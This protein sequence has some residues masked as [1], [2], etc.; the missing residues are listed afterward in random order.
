MCSPEASSTNSSQNGNDHVVPHQER[1]SREGDESLAYGVRNGA[2]EQKHCRDNRAH[3]LWC[4]GEGILETS[5]GGED[6][7]KCDEEVRYS[8]NPDVDGSGSRAGRFRRMFATGADFV[9]VVLGDACCN[10][11]KRGGNKPPCNLLQRR[12]ANSHAFEAWIYEQVTDRNENDESDRVNIV[13]EIVWGAVEFHGCGLRN[14]VI[15]HLIVREPVHWV[16]QEDSAGF[17]TATNFVDP[18]VVKSHPNRFV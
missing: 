17:E 1:V 12:E 6:L 16:P 18:N 5:D 14:Q 8:L 9:N 10:H 11:R 7:G 2:H 15:C 13:D 3:I 4:F